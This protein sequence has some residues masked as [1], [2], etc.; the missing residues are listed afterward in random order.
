MPPFKAILPSDSIRA[1]GRTG[2]QPS[3]L[4]LQRKRRTNMYTK[5]EL[6]VAG[7]AIEAVK[8]ANVKDG[9]TTDIANPNE[10]LSNGCAYE[11]DE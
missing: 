7:K 3:G 2:L 8:G 11:S 9:C 10:H 1:Q 5:P 6:V 4:K